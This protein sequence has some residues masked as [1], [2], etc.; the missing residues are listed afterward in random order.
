[1]EKASN[2]GMLTEVWYPRSDF[3]STRNHELESWTPLWSEN[4]LA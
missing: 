2:A 1:M 4:L 3:G